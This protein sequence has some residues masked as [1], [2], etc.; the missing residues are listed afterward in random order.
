MCRLLAYASAEPATLTTIVGPTLTDFVELSKEHKHGWG[1]TTCASIGGIQERE[2]DLAPAVESSLFADVASTKATD[3]ALVHLRLASKGLAVDLS[4]NHPFIHGDISFMH[5]GTIRPAS[6]IEHL[7]DAQL[8]TQLTS[9]TDSER[10]FFAILTKAKELGLIEAIAA[11]VKEIAATADYTSINSITLTPDF[12]IAV[13]QFN[14]AEQSEWTV[15][16]HY[17]LRFTK[18]D[19]AIKVASTGWGHDDWMPLTNGKMLVVNRADLSYKILD[20]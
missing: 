7:V 10:Y 6:S 9:T 12:L 17:E 8:L 1:L 5:N 15:P 13:C 16:F 18:E 3:G 14:V 4:N 11:T 19:G 20:I 2:R